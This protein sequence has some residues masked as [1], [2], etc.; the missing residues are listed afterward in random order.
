MGKGVRNPSVQQAASL[1][2]GLWLVS[3]RAFPGKVPTEGEQKLKDF[4]DQASLVHLYIKHDFKII[5][6][7]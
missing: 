3:E 4:K 1:I 6:D 5:F 2:T 7:Y